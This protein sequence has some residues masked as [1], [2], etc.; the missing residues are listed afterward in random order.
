LILQIS[1]YEAP[2][3][4][5]TLLASLVMVYSGGD[6]LPSER[7]MFAD[8]YPGSWIVWVRKIPHSF[9]TIICPYDLCPLSD[10]NYEVQ[11]A[12]LL[13]KSPLFYEETDPNSRSRS[14]PIEARR[15]WATNCKA[16]WFGKSW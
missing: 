10:P 13:Y 14:S 8:L 3:L 6:P 9:L 15:K 4:H 1:T 7:S 12:G 5:L 16:L 11:Q 2:S